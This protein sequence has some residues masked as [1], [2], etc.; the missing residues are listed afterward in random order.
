MSKK[1]NLV[2]AEQIHRKS[3]S[4]YEDNDLEI[5]KDNCKLCQSALRKRAEEEYD[6]KKGNVTAVVNFLKNSNEEISYNAVRNH[7]HFHYDLRK[8]KTTINEYSK[9]VLKWAKGIGAD[10][11]DALKARIGL[12]DREAVAIASESDDMGMEEKRKSMETVVKVYSIIEKLERQLTELEDAK[13]PATIVIERL[14]II[15]QEEMK[16]IKTVETKRALVHIL[17]QLQSQVGEFVLE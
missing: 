13:E 8:R 14:Q 4:P 7:L 17:E 2:V 9:D 11:V 10:R 3:L 1:N 16:S 6:N 12:L 15:I 5:T